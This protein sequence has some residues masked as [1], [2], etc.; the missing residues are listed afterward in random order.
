[1]I[2]D[3]LVLEI[4]LLSFPGMAG[5]QKGDQLSTFNH[6]ASKANPF[7][8]PEVVPLIDYAELSASVCLRHYWD[9]FKLDSWGPEEP[10]FTRVPSLRGSQAIS[11]DLFIKGFRRLLC[12]SGLPS[13]QFLGHSFRAG[14]ATD[15]YHGRCR[16]H[17]LQLQ[18]R[19]KSDTFWIYV[20]DR[21]DIRQ[22]EVGKAFA[23][24]VQ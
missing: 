9:L 19:W 10:L 14:G 24:M 3:V 2:S 12:L 4:V 15:L 23:R 16:P 17:M 18:G 22:A 7:G 6:V 11:K 8:L 5:R 20:R 13:A 1:V 21:P